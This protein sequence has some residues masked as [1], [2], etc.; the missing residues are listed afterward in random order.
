M[1]NNSKLLLI[2]DKAIKKCQ[3]QNLLIKVNH[4][5]ISKLTNQDFKYRFGYIE[6][7]VEKIDDGH[8]YCFRNIL[9]PNKNFSSYFTK[10]WIFYSELSNSFN[11]ILIVKYALKKYNIDKNIGF[12]I[13]KY[14]KQIKINEIYKEKINYFKKEYNVY[15]YDNAKIGFGMSNFMIST[16]Y[17]EYMEKNKDKFIQKRKEMINFINFDNIQYFHN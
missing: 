14:Y 8:F 11:I 17:I 15:H 13:F 7:G 6:N 4:I 2:I 1:D 3:K 5:S 10:A 16:H 12:I 9:P